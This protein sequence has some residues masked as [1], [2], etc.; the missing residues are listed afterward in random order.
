MQPRDKTLITDTAEFKDF[1]KDF[2]AQLSN[3]ALGLSTHF[4]LTQQISDWLRKEEKAKRTPPF[5]S[6]EFKDNSRNPQLLK[7]FFSR[8][9][10]QN[11]QAFA[12]SFLSARLKKSKIKYIP[13]TAKD[14]LAYLY[15][16]MSKA[17]G[18][19][20]FYLDDQLKTIDYNLKQKNKPAR[21][22][23]ADAFSNTVN[24]Y[25]KELKNSNKSTQ[26]AKNAQEI[27]KSNKDDSK[28][29]I[30]YEG[31]DEK[32]IHTHLQKLREV[33]QQLKSGKSITLG[34]E[35]DYWFPAGLFNQFQTNKEQIKIIDFII[36][37]LHS[38]QSS[39]IEHFMQINHAKE[40]K[41][42]IDNI[43]KQNE[44]ALLKTY[45]DF[46]KNAALMDNNL[47]REAL[48]KMF[49]ELF[50]LAGK[51]LLANK[52][53]SEAKSLKNILT[54]L[55]E[56]AI[57][58]QDKAK[59][60]D[61]IQDVLYQID[62]NSRI[63]EKHF[64][65]RFQKEKLQIKEKLASNHH[66]LQSAVSAQTK[67]YI[68]VKYKD[69]TNLFAK[70]IA[71][72]AKDAKSGAKPGG[73]Y[74][75]EDA[76]G[77]QKTYMVKYGNNLGDTISELF[78][79]TEAQLTA[80]RLNTSD[81]TTV[82]RTH[83]V[84]EDT[85]HNNLEGFGKHLF[86]ASEFSDSDFAVE[87][88]KLGGFSER[89][90]ALATRHGDF[91]TRLGELNEKCDLKLEIPL[92]TAMN[93]RDIDF[94]TGNVMLNFSTQS[95]S[96]PEKRIQVQELINELKQTIANYATR[97]DKTALTDKKHWDELAEKING[98]K[99]NGGVAFF[100]KID[101]GYGYN[102]YSKTLPLE[103]S[104]ILNSNQRIIGASTDFEKSKY[105]LT[106]Q[107]SNHIAEFTE[108]HRAR[109]TLF[110]EAGCKAILLNPEKQQLEIL[111]ASLII[112]Y[113]RLRLAAQHYSDPKEAEMYLLKSFYSHATGMRY[114]AEGGSIK[115]LQ[116]TIK[117]Y[118][119]ENRKKLL[120]NQD[121]FIKKELEPVVADIQ[122]RGGP[123]NA[124][125]MMQKDLL[126]ATN[127]KLEKRVVKTVERKSDEKASPT[128]PS[129]PSF[130]RPSI[131]K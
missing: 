55:N 71:T 10:A 62:I 1:Q 36:K 31:L 52:K 127:E 126:L 60:R 24:M 122:K 12:Q 40:T 116:E 121:V 32:T 115:D 124:K 129:L 118:L 26:D 49:S 3:Q 112:S 117:D 4:L 76:D 88:F 42:A 77:L 67:S 56:L 74:H 107:P 100:Q 104:G 113:D 73:I 19:E 45:K 82:A 89:P 57:L 70:T 34:K 130:P 33:K 59:N 128:K 17:L 63:V 8:M 79:D 120:H 69:E 84:V 47:V 66:S 48:T 91:F 43:S 15:R 119:I 16:A 25:L 20:V 103:T 94:H 11:K 23:K 37:Q 111:E 102:N 50:T 51:G 93:T 18:I 80:N 54:G 92:L 46:K 125:E 68:H 86:L 5:S 21:I 90:K 7:K 9:S 72:D 27:F 30:S 2:I 58:Y 131:R 114:R 101:H 85:K 44:T 98:I 123:Q 13:K 106:T 65:K 39:Q 81:M 64:D 105:K 78:V 29:Q 14:K 6:K 53:S 41:L 75:M 108:E 99:A 28:H 38:M 35:M 22:V 109:N 97:T 87:A 95:I 61:K 110:T 96:D 83:L